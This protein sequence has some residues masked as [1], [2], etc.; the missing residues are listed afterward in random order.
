MIASNTLNQIQKK[1]L[2]MHVY[3]TEKKIH[4]YQQVYITVIYHH[5]SLF[6]A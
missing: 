5:M 4:P 1:F 6:Y 3:E 2:K